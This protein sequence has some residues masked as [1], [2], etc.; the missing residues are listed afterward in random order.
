MPGCRGGQRAAAI[1]DTAAVNRRRPV[2]ASS[3]RTTGGGV[4][5]TFSPTS[6]TSKPFAKQR[7]WR[8]ARSRCAPWP[9]ILPVRAMPDWPHRRRAGFQFRRIKAP[10]A[11][12]QPR[13]WTGSPGLYE[14]SGRAVNRCAIGCRP[15]MS[16]KSFGDNMCQLYE[17]A[18]PTGWA[19]CD[20]HQHRRLVN[21]WLRRVRTKPV[22]RRA[23]QPTKDR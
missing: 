23:H 16:S 18:R 9:N 14:S 12:S 15:A 22:E 7:F 17:S 5:M 1:S 11:R 8:R 20:S 21:S 2:S 3:V 6:R 4:R 13:S 10:P 19:W